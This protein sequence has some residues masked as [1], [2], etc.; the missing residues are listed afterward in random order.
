MGESETQ[1]GV[2]AFVADLWSSSNPIYNNGMF[3]RLNVIVGMRC[4][5][6]DGFPPMY[7]EDWR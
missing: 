2:D 7:V 1:Q 6:S 5:D 4:N 3:L